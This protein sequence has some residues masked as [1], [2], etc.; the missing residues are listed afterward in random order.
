MSRHASA[1]DDYPGNGLDPGRYSL[2]FVY[3]SW[4]HAR[5]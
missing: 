5:V 1:S 4:Q 2:E 3:K